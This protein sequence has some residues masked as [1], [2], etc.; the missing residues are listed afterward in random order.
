MRLVDEA[1]RRRRAER[2]PDHAAARCRRRRRGRDAIGVPRQASTRRSAWRWSATSSMSPTPTRCC[3][4]PIARAR[5]AIT[6]PGAKV[7]DLPAGRCN[8]HWT[9]NIIAS[10][11]GTKLYVTVGSNSNVG[12]NGMAAEE[13]RA[14]IWEVD[15]GDAASAG[16]S[17]RA[18]AIPNGMA[19]ASRESGALW[20]AVNER[21]ELGS[22]LVPDYM[23]S[24]QGRRLLRL[25][26]QLLRPACRR[27]RQAAAAR[28]GRQ[29]DRARLRARSAHRL[30]RAWPSPTASVLPARYR[31]GAFVGQHGSWNRN[32]RSG[33]KVIFVPFAGGQPSGQP[34][35]RCWRT[36]SARRP[37]SSWPRGNRAVLPP[38]RALRDGGDAG[39]AR[40]PRVR[41]ALR[42]AAAPH[43]DPALHRHRPESVA[44]EKMEGFERPGV[45]VGYRANMPEVQVKLHL[46]PHI[47]ADA[48]RGRGAGAA[49]RRRV[50][51]RRRLRSRRWWGGAPRFAAAR[52]SR[53]RRAA[54]AG[55]SR[56]RLCAVPG[57]VGV[58]SRRGAW[59]TP[60]HEKVRQCGVVH[61]GAR[62]A[63]RGQRA[64]RARARG[65]HPRPDV[66]ATWGVGVPASP[67][68]R[69]AGRRRSPWA[70]STS[71][72][73]GRTAPPPQ[74]PPPLR[75]RAVSDLQRR[76][77]RWIS[78]GGRSPGCPPERIFP[79]VGHFPGRASA[80][81]R[82]ASW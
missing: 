51:R 65:G 38:R 56:R 50:R 66:G 75:S 33:Y 58:A 44:G 62:G 45:I 12:E 6:A 14:A 78:S 24:V 52:R 31:D 49:R 72:S 37:A 73:R 41:A 7:V 35:R 3:A 34:A 61:R 82:T 22:D 15:R 1:G 10:P 70:P 43:G 39:R 9:K 20:T 59:S 8:H 29:G 13:G 60:T 40:D 67:A 74:A 81:A 42:A 57:R 76:R 48:A 79:E 54:P 53:R 46:D 69:A 25:A 19:L 64:R 36:A 4:S 5:R 16:S 17:P 27:A 21:D 71:R 26:L 63:R 77:P 23:T 30:A 80:C 11:D 18:C 55:A 32:P 2:Q 28:S 68:R 47:D